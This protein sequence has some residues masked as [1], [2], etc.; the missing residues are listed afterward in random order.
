[1][2]RSCTL[3]PPHAAS[4]RTSRG[5]PPDPSDISSA[6]H[7]EVS[8]PLPCPH[9][10]QDRTSAWSCR[11]SAHSRP[12]GSPDDKALPG[13]TAISHPALPDNISPENWSAALTA[14]PSPPESGNEAGTG[15]GHRRTAHRTPGNMP[16]PPEYY[17]HAVQGQS[18]YI[19]APF[20]AALSHMPAIKYPWHPD[21]LHFSHKSGKSS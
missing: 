20:Q 5:F 2:Y 19:K 9:I 21:T 10:C 6:A 15:A 11:R 17:F 12:P 3:L 4:L 13:G 7:T 16:L 1:M 14:H 8:V 18:A